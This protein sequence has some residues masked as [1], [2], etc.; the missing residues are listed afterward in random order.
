M[1][2]FDNWFAKKC[3]QVWDEADPNNDT[4][5]YAK[6]ANIRRP[7]GPRTGLAIASTASERNELHSK[8]TSFNLYN[9]NGGYVIE[10]RRFDSNRDEWSTSLHIV[11]NGE[12]LGQSIDHI[13]TLEALKK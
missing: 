6:E 11:P 10:L 9:A 3:K 1:K 8:S 13:I 5:M 12:E 7:R 4:E 2:W